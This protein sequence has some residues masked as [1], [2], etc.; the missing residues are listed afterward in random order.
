MSPVLLQESGRG[1]SAPPKTSAE[2]TQTAQTAAVVSCKGRQVSHK[3][4]KITALDN[5]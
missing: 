5:K 1:S 2:E 3:A 4:L